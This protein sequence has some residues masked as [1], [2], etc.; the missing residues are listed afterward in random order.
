MPIFNFFFFFIS[1]TLAHGTLGVF[2]K[3]LNI[4]LVCKYITVLRNWKATH[5]L[6]MHLLNKY[7]TM[8][9]FMQEITIQDLLCTGHNFKG[10][11]SPMNKAKLL[12][13]MLHNKLLRIWSFIPVRGCRRYSNNHQF[14]N[15]IN[16]YQR[17]WV[18]FHKV[19]Q[20]MSEHE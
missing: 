17:A 16:L 12:C 2:K 1:W 9:I 19:T 6:H 8:T 11:N 7:L 13:Y 3:I 18:V 14:Y 20:L 4:F 10:S 5:A 15:Q